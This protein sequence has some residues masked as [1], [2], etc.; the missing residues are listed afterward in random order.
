ML[1]R[2]HSLSFAAI[3]LAGSL[4]ATSAQSAPEPAEALARPAARAPK[5]Y[6]VFLAHF[7]PVTGEAHGGVCGS[8]FFISPTRAM[9]AFHV[10]QPRSFADARTQIW[11]VH[12]GEPAIE[13][14]AEEITGDSAHD[15]TTIDLARAVDPKYV[16]K[17]AS[18]PEGDVETDGFIASSA[19]PQLAREGRRLK[20]TSVPHLERIHAEG[21]IVRGATPVTLTS[22]DVNLRDASCVQLSY[23][24]IVGLSGGPVFKGDRVYAMNSFADP[25]ARESTWAVEIKN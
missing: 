1:H 12:E 22:A 21:R 25:R 15:T 16:F 13:L 11:L 3:V 17:L 20:I 24:P 18:A 9:T 5:S 10:L 23:Q 6:A 19:G 8:A 14:S 2:A 4:A 7:D